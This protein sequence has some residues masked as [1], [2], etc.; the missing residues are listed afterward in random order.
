M[1]R[2]ALESGSCGEEMRKGGGVAERS[3]P[4][5]P[6]AAAMCLLKSLETCRKRQHLP[7]PLP[8]IRTESLR[9]VFCAQNLSA[10]WAQE[11]SVFAK[12]AKYAKYQQNMCS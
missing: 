9:K 7:K 1:D 3:T 6:C 8:R 10:E 11:T 12:Y 4:A 5:K 2:A